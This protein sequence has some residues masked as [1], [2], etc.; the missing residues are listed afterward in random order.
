MFRARKKILFVV[1]YIFTSPGRR[2]E[3]LRGPRPVLHCVT[4]CYL[5]VRKQ[6][7]PG[8]KLTP[9]L[10]RTSCLATHAPLCLISLPSNNQNR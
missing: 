4:L 5:I 8:N 3:Y 7:T 10:P 2:G 1:V 9:K 6:G